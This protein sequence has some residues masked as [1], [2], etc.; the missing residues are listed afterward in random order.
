MGKNI[1]VYFTDEELKMLEKLSSLEPGN[2]HSRALKKALRKAFDDILVFK[3]HA[4]E[5]VILSSG[6]KKEAKEKLRPEIEKQFKKDLLS[7]KIAKKKEDPIDE[8]IDEVFKDL[9]GL[10]G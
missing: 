3:D 5:I 1:G 6:S 9:D 10:G 4:D 8:A 7:K 2:S